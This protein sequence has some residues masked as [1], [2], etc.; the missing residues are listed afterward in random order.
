[1]ADTNP[2]RALNVV[3]RIEAMCDFLEHPTITT[4]IEQH[5]PGSMPRAPGALGFDI[6]L[7]VGLGTV[8]L[9]AALDAFSERAALPNHKKC[10]PE[11][12]SAPYI[13]GTDGQSLK[14]LDDLRHLYAHNY[15]GE[16]DDEY[17]RHTRHVLKPDV[18]VP[19][20]CGATFDGRRLGL[21]LPHLRAYSRTV[22]RVL[23]RF[24]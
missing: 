6:P 24:P 11:R 9:W 19:L 1:M 17:F 14:E 16:A 20:T 22:I 5:V 23:Q 2:A 10:M 7:W 18:P 3:R 4:A 15:A 21:D 12:F 13:Q 8:G